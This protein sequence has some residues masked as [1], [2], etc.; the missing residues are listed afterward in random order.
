MVIIVKEGNEYSVDAVDNRG[1][2]ENVLL[3]LL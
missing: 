2:R 3:S 1:V